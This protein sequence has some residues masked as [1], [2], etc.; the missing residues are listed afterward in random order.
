MARLTGTA[1]ALTMLFAASAQAQ[2]DRTPD[3]GTTV[4]GSWTTDRY[5][6]CQFALANGVNGRNNVLQE[7]VCNA[8]AAGNRP[9]PYSSTFYNTQ[10]RQIAIDGVNTAPG[11]SQKL[12]LDLWV[13]GSWASSAN[14]LVSTG[15]WARVN[16]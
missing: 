4:P 6:P 16:Q 5:A 2:T 12:S 1:L 9:G 14:G 11:G 15:M 8:D 10:G 3:L 13:D 7:S